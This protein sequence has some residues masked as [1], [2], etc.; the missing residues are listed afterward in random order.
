LVYLP[1]TEA[2]LNTLARLNAAK[3]GPFNAIALR[4]TVGIGVSVAVVLIGLYVMT[5]CDYTSIYNNVIDYRFLD[6]HYTVPL[7]QIDSVSVNC[8]YIHQGGRGASSYWNK[9]YLIKFKG[10]S[11]NLFNADDPRHPFSDVKNLAAILAIDTYIQSARGQVR[12]L[13]PQAAEG[14]IDDWPA[15][16]PSGRSKLNRILTD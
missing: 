12:K 14:C 16:D 13:S 6:K 4:I 9:S 2:F 1:T 11:I 7:S 10:I 5:G 8:E 15:T 3:T